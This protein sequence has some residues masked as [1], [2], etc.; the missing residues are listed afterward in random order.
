MKDYVT[1]ID[2][3]PYPVIQGEGPNIGQKMLLLRFKGCN[4]KCPNCDSSETWNT[5]VEAPKEKKF[6][7][8]N[9][10]E[11]LD[12]Q[13]GHLRINHLLLTGGEPQL[14]EKQIQKLIVNL[15]PFQFD[16]ETNGSLR[17]QSPFFY[18]NTNLHFNFSP[19][20]GRLKPSKENVEW[21]GLERLPLKYCVKVVVSKES[22]EQDLIEI[23][24]LQQKYN[25]P[26]NHI[27]LMPFGQTREE[28]IKQS[29]FVIEQCIA[30]NFNFSPRMHILI[31]DN[32]K[33]V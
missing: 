15:F 14:W 12:Y 31:Y 4:L 5:G 22:F 17:W 1:L 33:L 16:I 2:G 9:F 11:I 10:L 32:K 13:T 21:K 24:N 18:S 28:I 3:A 27:Y 8:G 20:I 30:F 26:D 23:E 29:P 7:I 6:T 25:I 19:K